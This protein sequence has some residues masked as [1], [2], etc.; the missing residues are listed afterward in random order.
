MADIALIH[1]TWRRWLTLDF[2]LCTT[3]MFLV[4]FGCAVLGAPSPRLL[5][6]IVCQKYYQDNGNAFIQQDC[7]TQE[8]QVRFG[9]VL[10]VISTCSVLAATLMQIPMGVLADKKGLRIALTLNILGTILY[11]GWIPFAFLSGLPTWTIYAG[12]IFV[13]I[14]GGPWASGALVFAAINRRISAG[15]RTPVFSIMEAL[16][17]IA[18][19]VGPALGT[20]T[21]EHHIWLPFL[22]ATLVFALMFV[23]TV[24]LGE[25]PSHLLTKNN[26]IRSEAEVSGSA[27]SETQPLLQATADTN[28]FQRAGTTSKSFMAVI[29]SMTF[30]SFFLISLARDSTNFLIPW[31]SWR[32]NESMA[33]AGLIFSLRAIVSSV[34]FFV[35]LPLASSLICNIL[36]ADL[37]TRDLLMSASS[38]LLLCAGSVIIAVSSTVPTLVVGFC[39]MTLGS[40]VTVSL[41]A[42]LASKVDRSLS[43]R[44]FAATSATST[45][46]SLLGMPLMGTLY[47]LSISKQAVNVSLPFATAAVAYFL[48][49]CV[50]G[51]IQL[52]LYTLAPEVT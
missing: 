29:Y 36:K 17:G 2:W 26:D 8:I 42:F 14:G 34:V 51:S 41:R 28:D 38:A 33:R 32:F 44:F 49:S 39:I 37:I 22:L 48:V 43:G 10:T 35:L 7:K 1:Q 45:I 46:G 31:I 23:P 52:L 13:F 4:E 18:D 20:L 21:M 27:D 9:F 47:S 16:S 50:I 30:G 15:E 40:G 3:L 12:P 11:W 25:Q 6:I 19:L 5:E 24:F